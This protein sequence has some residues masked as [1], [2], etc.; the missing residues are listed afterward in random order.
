MHLNPLT[1]AVQVK[2]RRA[3]FLGT[4]L[5]VIVARLECPARLRSQARRSPGLRDLLGEE[6]RNERL[7]VL[8][9]RIEDHQ[10]QRGEQLLNQDA[11][12]IDHPGPRGVRLSKSGEE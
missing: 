1:S 8:V 7:C 10:A 12:G 4:D 9:R 3:V 11:E 6:L 2:E 5:R